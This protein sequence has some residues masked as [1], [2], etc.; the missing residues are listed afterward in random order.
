MTWNQ[1]DKNK[2]YR[3]SGRKRCFGLTYQKN[4][5]SYYVEERMATG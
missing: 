1:L 2:P 5:L 3:I 4:V